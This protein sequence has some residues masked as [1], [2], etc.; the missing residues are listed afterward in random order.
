MNRLVV[1]AMCCL[2]SLA[3]R[4]YAQLADQVFEP[5]ERKM[6]AATVDHL[7]DPDSVLFRGVVSGFFFN[8]SENRPF[9]CGKL[10]AKN[11]HGGY[12]GYEPFMIV[13][14]SEDV[15]TA[16]YRLIDIGGLASDLCEKARKSPPR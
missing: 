3:G 5:D 14:D 13:L 11:A 1:V 8:G 9:V 10:N 2:F 6:V 4:A 12:S 7:R 16:S 15:R